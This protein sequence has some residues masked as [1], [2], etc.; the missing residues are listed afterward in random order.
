MLRI[1]TLIILLISFETG[2][3]AQYWSSAGSGIGDFNNYG[4]VYAMTTH[5]GDLYVGGSFL[6]A[7]GVMANHVAKWDGTNWSPLGNGINGNV[8]AL[9]TYN[10]QLYAA[11]EF[12]MADSITAYNIAKWDGN[13]WSEVGTGI[14]DQYSGYGSAL[15]VYNGELYVSGFFEDAG[16]LPIKSIAK[17]NGNSWSPVGSGLTNSNFTGYVA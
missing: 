8:L 7:G 13:S 17:W 14:G 16:G 15:A 4:E 1:Y 3:K 10:G 6:M 2:S 5:N 9:I 12:S 11:G